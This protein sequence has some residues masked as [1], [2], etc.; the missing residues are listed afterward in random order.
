M[1]RA[2]LQLMQLRM[3]DRLQFSVEAEP[4]TERLHCPPMTLLTLV[5]NA[6][7]TASTRAR[8][9]VASRSACAGPPAAAPR[10]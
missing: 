10:G 8:R 1:V 2:Y 3:P 5:E 6:V 4:G 9:A 7:R